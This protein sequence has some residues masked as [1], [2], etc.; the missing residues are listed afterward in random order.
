MP[1]PPGPTPRLRSLIS[2]AGAA[3]IS[4]CGRYR[5]ALVRNWDPAR[6]R[7]TFVGLNPSTADALRDDPTVRRMAG[8][9]RAWGCGGLLVGNLFALRATNPEALIRERDPIGR[10]ND[11][12]LREL[13]SASPLVVAA[14]GNR[15]H[16]AARDQAVLSFSPRWHYFGRTRRGAPAHP[17]Y[18]R[19]ECR[20]HPW[21]DSAS[22]SPR[23]RSLRGRNP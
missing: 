22:P 21:L 11:R 2:S 18:L 15:G 8:F 16:L 6:P 1:M 7:V 20:P 13:I 9:A 12:W 3:V 23:S 4:R 10:A 17:L 14:W 19:R 5:Y